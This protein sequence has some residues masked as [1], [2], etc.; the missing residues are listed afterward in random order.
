LLKELDEGQ[1]A[2][3]RTAEAVLPF[4]RRAPQINPVAPTEPRPVLF[5]GIDEDDAGFLKD[6]L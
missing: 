4:G 5:I 6:A 3:W 1:P 2:G